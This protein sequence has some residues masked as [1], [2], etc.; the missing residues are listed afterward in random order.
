MYVPYS[1]CTVVSIIFPFIC[2]DIGLPG[3]VPYQI[4]FAGI[5][6]LVHGFMVG[7]RCIG[8]MTDVVILFLKCCIKIELHRRSPSSASGSLCLFL[9]YLAYIFSSTLLYIVRSLHR[10]CVRLLSISGDPAYVLVN[11]MPVK[12]IRKPDFINATASATSR[13]RLWASNSYTISSYESYMLYLRV[14]CMPSIDSF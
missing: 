9:Q 12:P 2:L 1:R 5:H 3:L 13:F 14:N 7:R 10:S 11:S 6:S 4:N 8:R